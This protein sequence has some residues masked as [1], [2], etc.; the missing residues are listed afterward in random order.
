MADNEEEHRSALQQTG[1]W[2]KRGAGCVFFSRYT[3][4]FCLAHRSSY[5]EQPNTWGTWGGAIDQ[6]ESP[7]LAVARE[8]HEEAGYHG[9]LALIPLYIFRHPSGFTYYN[10]LAAVPDEFTPAMNWETR[11][12]GWFEYG[13]WPSNLHFGFVKLLEDPA[14]AK[15]MQHYA[16]L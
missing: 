6:G 10:F 9:E 3:R 11:G 4:K 13:D 14:S 16:T 15:I 2:G 12:F 1:F 5:V 8:A 7:E